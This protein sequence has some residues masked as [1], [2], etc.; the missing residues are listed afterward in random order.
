MTR[1][2][3]GYAICWLACARSEISRYPATTTPS[4]SWKRVRGS[5]VAAAHR[6]RHRRIPVRAQARCIQQV[7]GRERRRANSPGRHRFHCVLDSDILVDRNFVQRNTGRL[8]R[9]DHL[10][11][12]PFQWAFNLS[13][14]A[15]S[16][17]IRHRVI[18]GNARPAG[19]P[20]LPTAPS[21]AT[22]C[23]S[24]TR[25]GS[26]AAFPLF[27]Q[28]YPER[29]PPQARNVGLA[30]RKASRKGARHGGVSAWPHR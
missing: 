25:N 27:S 30:G 12:L 4:P 5:A 15:S 13:Q 28:R 1:P 26:F 17:A 10:V 19:R 8:T 2:A 24:V 20:T 18:D 29:L 21:T 9:G 7:V 14:Q 6:A 11:H 3:G 23:H 22:H 16:W